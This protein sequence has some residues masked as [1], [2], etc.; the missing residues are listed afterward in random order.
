MVTLLEISLYVAVIVCTFVINRTQYDFLLALALVVAV[1][2]TCSG[3]SIAAE[4]VNRLAGKRP[5]LGRLLGR[6][7][8]CVYLYNNFF[9][10]IAWNRPLSIMLP[11]YLLY[12]FGFPI[13]AMLIVN[14]L[15]KI[16]G[17]IK[18][19]LYEE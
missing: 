18:R 3:K 10:Y 8:L 12:A 16:G 4:A 7:S 11:Y 1:G 15:S 2:I 9:H 19:S 13:L 6:Y 17:A 14:E 5:A